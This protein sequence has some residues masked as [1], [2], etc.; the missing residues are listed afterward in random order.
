MSHIHRDGTTVGVDFQWVLNPS[1]QV[2]SGIFRDSSVYF[3]IFRYSA[4]FFGKGSAPWREPRAQGTARHL[5][6]PPGRAV[7]FSAY[8]H[9]CWG[10]GIFLYFLYIR[11]QLATDHI[12]RAPRFPIGSTQ[13]PT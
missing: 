9:H 5:K 10:I 4:G 12:T 8:D 6:A 7:R 3:V 1:T 13:A 2:F 11:K